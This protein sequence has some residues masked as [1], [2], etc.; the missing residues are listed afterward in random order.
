MRK[1]FFFILLILLLIPGLIWAQ[2]IKPGVSITKDN[3]ERYLP[4]LKKLLFPASFVTVLNALRKGWITLPVV[5]ER[6]KLLR[7]PG[8]AEWTKRMQGKCKVGAENR[9]IGWVA[10]APFDPPRSGA[11]LAW[12][13]ER[14]HQA[15]N[16][17]F[18]FYAPFFLFDKEGKLERSFKWH[19]YGRFWVGRTCIPP[20]PEE[21]GNNRVI[22][23]KESF[24]ILEPHDVKGFSQVRI[25]YEEVGRDDEAFSYIPA[26]RRMRRLTG[27][28][29]TD[30]ILGSDEVS[31][32]FECWRQKINSK[33]TFKMYGPKEFLV[34][35]FHTRK[36]KVL[37]GNS[38]QVNW[39]IRPLWIL[40][41]YT[42]DPEYA[43]KK[44]VIYID[45]QE[46]SNFALW[47]AENYD[48]RGRLWRSNSQIIHPL[49]PKTGVAPGMW[50]NC[51]K[52][53]HLTDHSTVLDMYPVVNDPKCTHEVFNIRHLLKEAR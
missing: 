45:S 26:I 41:V 39:Q 12:D 29:I 40:E 18:S 36:E 53:N 38:I 51:L 31:D 43:Y 19:I 2:E 1:T 16:N 25:R 15:N 44:R 4:E 3:Y 20:I 14:C 11:E 42:N 35:A 6:R 30:P 21:P 47:G 28:D 37:K 50:Y 34:P 10:G 13:V 32:D 49:D 24:V 8:Y 33:M 27:A 7:R 46:K 17:Q 48:Q 22:R 52:Y 9:L 5:E 23:Q